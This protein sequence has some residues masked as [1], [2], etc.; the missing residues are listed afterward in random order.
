TLENQ[1]VL[2]RGELWPGQPLEWE[3]S[4]DAPQGGD[5]AAAEA[6][7]AW[8]S[9][10]RF[11]LPLLGKVSGAIRLVGQRLHMQLRTETDA[12]ALALRTHGAELADALSAAGSPLDSLTVK[13]D[14]AEP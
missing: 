9:V 10:V 12:A 7:P 3:I 8:H 1:R 5:P 13:R 2:W 14:A 6:E 4:K 11:E